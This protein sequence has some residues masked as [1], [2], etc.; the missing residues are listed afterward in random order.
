LRKSNE[1]KGKTKMVMRKDAKK[2][3]VLYFFEM[4]KKIGR[5]DSNHNLLDQWKY[6]TCGSKG[7]MRFGTLKR[8]KR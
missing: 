7:R 5:G 8:G 3:K 2:E 1:S 6:P 4:G